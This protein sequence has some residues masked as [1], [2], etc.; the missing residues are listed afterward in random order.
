MIDW[1]KLL[2]ELPQS[3]REIAEVI[4]YDRALCMIGNLPRTT[5]DKHGERAMLY[6]PQTLTP[7]H[8]LIDALNMGGKADADAALKAA[9]KLVEHF[10]GEILHPARFQSL[11]KANRDHN[12]GEALARGMSTREVADK[13]GISA[14][15]VRNI[16]RKFFEK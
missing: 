12:I 3:V 14:R 15:Q 11:R 4:G 13:L 2:A 10:G 8:P 1:D 5:D 9:Q 16:G 6:V 7:D